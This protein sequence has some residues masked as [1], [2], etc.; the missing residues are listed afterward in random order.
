P[1]G[2]RLEVLSESP[3]VFG[4]ATSEARHASNGSSLISL[5]TNAADTRKVLLMVAKQAGVNI[6]VAPDV[7]GTVTLA[8]TDIA[9]VDAL[10]AVIIQAGLS[11][12]E[13]P[14]GVALSTL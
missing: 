1:G 4:T 2:V 7:R 5:R 6:E 14:R 8:L 9:A 10:H 11:V 12:L 13:P 3:G